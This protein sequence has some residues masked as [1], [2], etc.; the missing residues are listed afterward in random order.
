VIVI[1]AVLALHWE[2]YL[3]HPEWVTSKIAGT[4]YLIVGLLGTAAGLVFYLMYTMELHDED[5]EEDWGY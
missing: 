3:A 2:V 5:E 4:A 1:F